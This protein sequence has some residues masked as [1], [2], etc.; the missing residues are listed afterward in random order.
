MAEKLRVA[1]QSLELPAHAANAEMPGI[2][3]SIGVATFPGDAGEASLLLDAADSALYASKRATVSTRRTQRRS[4][5]ATACSTRS[6]AAW[7]HVSF[8]RLK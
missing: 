5:A 1:L 6:P 4:A 2:T 8:S 7:P 3:A